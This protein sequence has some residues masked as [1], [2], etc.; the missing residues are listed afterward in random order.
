M[1]G[2]HASDVLYAKSEASQTP[3]PLAGE[4]TDR[5]GIPLSVAHGPQTNLPV[6]QFIHKLTTP[7][8]N[9][10]SGDRPYTH[11][12]VLCSAS[13]PV[14]ATSKRTVTWRDALMRQRMSTNAVAHMQRVHPDEFVT[15]AD[16]KQRKREA[17]VEKAA[18]GSNEPKKKRVKRTPGPKKKSATTPDENREGA[19][20]DEV[21]VTSVVKTQTTGVSPRK[22]TP[23]KT[24]DHVRT[25]LISSGLP[26]SVLQD[27]SLQQLLKLSNSAI[28]ALSTASTFNAQVQEEFIKFSGFLG[29][30]LA[31]ESQAA[32]GLP[33]LSLRHEFRPIDGATAEDGARDDV[34]SNQE[35]AFLSVAVGFIDS[36][37]RRVDLVLTAKQVPR[38]WSQQVNQLVTQTV[39]DTYGIPSIS[40]YARFHVDVVEASPSSLAV[41]EGYEASTDEHEDVLTRT[42]RHCVVDALGVGAT[43]SFGGE[44]SVRR[45]VRLLQELL[46]YFEAPDRANMLAEIGARNA[47]QVTF[48]SASSIDALALSSLTSIGAMAELLRVSCCRYRAYCLYFQSSMRPTVAEPELETAWTQLSMDDWQTVTEIEAILNHLTQFRLEE[49]VALRPGAVAPSY[50]LLFRR[51]LS[52][53]VSVSSLKCLSLEDDAAVGSSSEKRTTRRKAKRVDMF[54]STGRQCMEQLREL[55]TQHLASPTSVCEVDDEI[56]A[57]LLDPRM[58]SKAGDLVSDTCVFRRAQEALRQEHRAVFQL[59]AARPSDS[60]SS[61]EEEVEEE[62]EDDEMSSLLMV[63]GPKNQPPAAASTTSSGRGSSDAVAEDEARAWR[64]W[65]QVYVAWDTLASEGADLFDKGQYNL[66]KLYHHVDILKWFREVGQQAHPAASLL[67]RVY[68]GQQRP[69]SRA[70]GTSLLQFTKQEEA[71]W[72]TGAVERA[73]KRCILHHNWRQ[74]QQLSADAAVVPAKDEGIKITTI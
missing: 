33:F 10:K 6:W 40:K 60:R 71:D 66:L 29:L 1:Q 47:V 74:Y 44:T 5:H 30:Y 41:S 11:I 18:N 28:S 21:P 37:W 67:A 45:L 34:V 14:R 68:L 38:S 55:I 52:V 7:L 57:M 50:A 3:H 27:A 24:T 58:S 69:P 32:L 72:V 36:Q 4:P 48:S 25:W 15:I 16:Y 53:T 19:S 20:A 63:D 73:E 2:H 56:K 64:E 22:R 35:K 17:L 39:S 62:D 49:R 46:T 59:L 65:Q 8:P 31:S 23:G 61:T 42:L 13:P 43:S 54:T 9:P 51:L 26:V 12:C 70:L